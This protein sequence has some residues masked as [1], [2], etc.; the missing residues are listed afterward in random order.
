MK[1]SLPA[2]HDVVLGRDERGDRTHHL[3]TSGQS[4]MTPGRINT[5]NPVVPASAAGS[6]RFTPRRT[7]G[8]PTTMPMIAHTPRPMS[9]ASITKGSG[10]T[11]RSFVL[12]RRFKQQIQKV[13]DE[14]FGARETKVIG[15][16]ELHSRPVNR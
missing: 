7:N 10:E 2:C 9:S 6:R 14:G 5:R 1:A 13:V 4:M 15:A 8:T 3:R 16:D 11:R 12:V